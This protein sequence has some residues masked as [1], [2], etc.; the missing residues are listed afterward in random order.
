MFL[1]HQILEGQLLYDTRIKIRRRRRKRKKTPN[2]SKE[3]FEIL[4][5]QMVQKSYRLRMF[6]LVYSQ[7]HIF[8]SDEGE[9]F[10]HI[11]GVFLLRGLFLKKK[12]AM[13]KKKRKREKEKKRKREKEKKKK[14][15][16]ERERKSTNHFDN[17]RE[18][19]TFGLM[20]LREEEP[21]LCL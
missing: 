13:N 21:F 5:I 20:V 16:K 2:V 17:L 11:V 12:V 18:F 8:Y 9:Q 6:V 19:V 3:F 10:L 15:E 1:S 7:L 4:H 14:R